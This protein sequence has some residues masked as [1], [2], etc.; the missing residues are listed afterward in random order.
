MEELWVFLSK[1]SLQIINTA[2]V[3]QWHSVTLTDNQSYYKRQNKAIPP[4][5]GEAV[6][7]SVW[8]TAVDE[9]TA[10]LNERSNN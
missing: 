3:E 1:I 4:P 2:G 8:Q 7:Y 5:Y 9:I 10:I 6:T